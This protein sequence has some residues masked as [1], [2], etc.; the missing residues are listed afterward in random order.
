MK[1][2]PTGLCLI[3]NN[4][5]FKIMNKDSF[6]DKYRAGS[7]KDVAR[8][9]QLFTKLK[10]TVDVRLNRTR[11]QIL[12]QDFAEFIERLNKNKESFDALVLIIMSHGSSN[13]K[14]YDIDNYPIEVGFQNSYFFPLKPKIFLA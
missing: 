4:S 10:F 5:Q 14:I 6:D 11:D 1:N 12:K 7:A 13:D 3:I 8:L 2:D 9:E